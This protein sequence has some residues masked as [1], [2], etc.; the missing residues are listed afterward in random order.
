LGIKLF[1]AKIGRV[2]IGK[3]VT[4]VNLLISTDENHIFALDSG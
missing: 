1:S 3:G 2:L 4:A